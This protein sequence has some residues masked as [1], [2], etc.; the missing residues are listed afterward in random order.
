MY[1]TGEFGTS[2]PLKFNSQETSSGVET[3]IAEQLASMS[4]SLKEDNFD[5]TSKPTYVKNSNEK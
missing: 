2:F 5:E 4:S 3:T 1:I